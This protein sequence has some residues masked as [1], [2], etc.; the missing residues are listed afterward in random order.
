VW[1]GARH[2]Q[3]AGIRRSH[4]GQD[5]AELAARGQTCRRTRGQGREASLELAAGS[6][7]AVAAGQSD[8]VEDQAPGL[9][10]QGLGVS[11]A[12]LTA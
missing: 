8:A 11:P 3:Q 6:H 2:G 4:F 10:V 5:A 7:G 9:E 1:R 12:A